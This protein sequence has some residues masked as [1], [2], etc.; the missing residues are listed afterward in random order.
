MVKLTNNALQ[1]EIQSA[2][3]VELNPN[4]YYYLQN[5]NF[6]QWLKFQRTLPL[7]E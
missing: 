2:C 1:P 6:G 4:M 3:V 7:A 5:T